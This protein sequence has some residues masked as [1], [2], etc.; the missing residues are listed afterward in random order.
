VNPP[1]HTTRP[2]LPSLGARGEGWVL[3]QVILVAGVIAGGLLGTRWPGQGRLPRLVLAASLGAVAAW[4]VVT[5]VASLGRSITPMPR[6]HGRT[7]L[8]E[9]GPYAMVRHP[10]YG[11]L[12]LIALAWSLLTSPWALIPSGVLMIFFALK[13]RL[14][15]YWLTELYSGYRRYA[16]R[17]QH[18]FIPYVW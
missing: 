4:L 1:P 11:G 12:I 7:V 3:I 16:R 13:A 5:A 6:P 8:K 10:I 17:V 18:R 2:R 14:E 15:E 9:N